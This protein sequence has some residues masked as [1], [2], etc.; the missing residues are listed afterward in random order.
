MIFDSFIFAWPVRI[1]S[2]DSAIV[3]FLLQDKDA[4]RPRIN[5]TV[6]VNRTALKVPCRLKRRDVLISK[7]HTQKKQ[8]WVTLLLC[9][10]CRT[11]TMK[12]SK[13]S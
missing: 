12:T 1:R 2:K 13:P 9:Y 11:I 6:Y 5:A 4:L 10:L 3:S 8:L 7:T